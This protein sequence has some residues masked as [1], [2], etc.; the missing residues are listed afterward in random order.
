MTFLA[1]RGISLLIVPSRMPFQGSVSAKRLGILRLRR[2]IRER[3]VSLHS[4][5]QRLGGELTAYVD[6]PQL[7]TDMK[8]NL[9]W[10]SARTQL[11]DWVYY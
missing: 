10:E 7:S 5:W 9:L 1:S 6:L 4:G 11:V 8:Y 2:T 3:I